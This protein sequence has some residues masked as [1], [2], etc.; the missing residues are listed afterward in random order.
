MLGYVCRKQCVCFQSMHARGFGGAALS[1]EER[2]TIWD[3][4]ASCMGRIE[5]AGLGTNM[6]G[7]D[8][9]SRSGEEEEGERR[10]VPPL[11]GESDASSSR[12]LLAGKC[13]VGFARRV[14]STGLRVWAL[15]AG[16]Q[17]SVVG[18]GGR[19]S[20]LR[21]AAGCRR[22]VQNGAS[23][24]HEG[25]CWMG[26]E[27][28]QIRETHLFIVARHAQAKLILRNHESCGRREQRV[29]P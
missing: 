8:A 10:G 26:A 13:H 3:A 5:V 27:P 7:S 24:R 29:R 4:G 20:R 6:R 9:D 12:N 1:V 22:C 19:L 18:S 11:G 28:G 17:D 21:G 2:G 14:A 16:S 23:L 15:E 25:R